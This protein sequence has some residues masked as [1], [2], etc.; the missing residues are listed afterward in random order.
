VGRFLAGVINL[1]QLVRP[2]VV[3]LIGVP[4]ESPPRGEPEHQVLGTLVLSAY[5]R[6]GDVR[7]EPARN[8][9]LPGQTGGQAAGP[10]GGADE[11]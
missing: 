11:G 5:V 7:M 8:A 1:P 4:V 10:A 6:P 2:E 9:R 3:A